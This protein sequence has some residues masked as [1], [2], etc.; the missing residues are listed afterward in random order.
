MGN[1]KKDVYLAIKE[2]ILCEVK[3]VKTVQL[4]NNQ[5]NRTNEE[6]AFLYPAAFIE[7]EQLLWDGNTLQT[8]SGNTN[9]KIYATFERYNTDDTTF[10]DT[11]QEIY[12]ALQ[13][14]GGACFSGLQRIEERQD[15][16]HDQVIIWEM[17]FNTTITDGEADPRLKRVPA[18]ITDLDILTDLD[19]DNP[20]IRTGDGNFN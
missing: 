13:G 12:V 8:Q 11:V 6:E 20:V 4:W 16:D 17:I 10:F 18:T 14:F 5:P 9:I 7:Y 2:Q 19:I 15:I 3:E 1:P